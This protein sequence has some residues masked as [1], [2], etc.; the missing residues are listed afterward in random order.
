MCVCVHMHV[1]VQPPVAESLEK[2]VREA[3]FE[4]E[5]L[6][7]VVRELRNRKTKLVMHRVWIKA[8]FRAPPW[9][10]VD[11]PHPHLPHLNVV[12]IRGPSTDPMPTSLDDPRVVR[13]ERKRAKLDDADE[14]EDE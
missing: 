14:D 2:L 13:H 4:V 9:H 11:K 6:E 1:Y 7:Y 5:E 12:R 8:I 3:G 10:P